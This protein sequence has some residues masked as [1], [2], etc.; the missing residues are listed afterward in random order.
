VFLW[1]KPGEKKVL[2]FSWT[3]STDDVGQGF[4]FVRLPSGFESPKPIP[5]TVIPKDTEQAGS[6]QPATRPESKSEDNDK[7]QPEAE[8]RSR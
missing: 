3:A 4:L 1:I 2:R 7:P 5:I 6:G 8:G